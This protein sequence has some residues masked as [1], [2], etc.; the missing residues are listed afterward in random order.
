MSLSSDIQSLS[1]IFSEHSPLL[2]FYSDFSMVC[3]RGGSRLLPRFRFSTP[4]REAPAPAPVPA[5]VPS[6]VLE[7]VPEEPQGFRRYQTRMGPRAPS[8]VPQRRVTRARP[9]KQARTSGP[10][11]SSSSRPHPSPVTSAAEAT[12][13]PQLSPASRIRKPLFL[14]NPIP[15]NARLHRREFHQESYYDVLTLMADPRFRESMRLIEDYSLLPFMTP[16]QHYYPRVVLQ[17]YHSM[18]SRGA[19]G[20]LELQFSIDDRP[21]VLRAADI[22]AALGMRIPQANAEGYRAWAHPPHR[23]MVRSLARNTTAGPVFYRRQLPLQMLLIDYLFRTS[24]FPLQHYVQRRGAILEAL[25]RISEGFWL[26]PF[27]LVMTSLMHSEDK[28]HRK[29]LAR[30]ESLPLLMPRLLLHVLEH[31][32]F[33][34][35]PRIEMRVR[36]PLVLSVERVMTMPI[37]FHLRRQDQ[38]EVPGQV[39]DDSQHPLGTGRYKNV[40]NE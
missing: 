1:Y 24:L 25:Y 26:S 12:S 10:G 36:C 22:S 11:E 27:E 34:A 38:E 21:G 18:T 40:I 13:S 19:A 7:A 35:E 6:P 33:P 2:V 23:E 17:F 20:P 16:R 32:G 31:M 28:V 15:R 14:G 4:E 9:S 39:A 5:P 37:Y 29:D 8:P 3:I 30:A